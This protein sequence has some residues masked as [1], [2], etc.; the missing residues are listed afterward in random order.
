MGDFNFNVNYF[1]TKLENCF[2]FYY[3]VNLFLFNINYEYL[4]IFFCLFCALLWFLT[5]YTLINKLLFFFFKF[6]MPF[7]YSLIIKLRSLRIYF[8][9]NRINFIIFFFYLI[10]SCAFKAFKVVCAIS[11]LYISNVIFDDKLL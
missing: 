7:S 9:V 11:L 5:T 6:S 2:Y 1:L 4:L 8:S 10:Y 3:Y